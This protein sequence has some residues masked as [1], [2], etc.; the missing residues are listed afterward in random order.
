MLIPC[1]PSSLDL[2]AIADTVNIVTLAKRPAAFVLNAV[3][4][5]SS[6]AEDAEEALSAYPIPIAPVRIASRVVYVRSLAEG[7]GVPEFAPQGPAALEI[8][9]LFNF[10]SH[11]GGK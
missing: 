1:Q 11:Y 8:A 9:A 5:S 10:I 3:R 7:K 2:D 4:T 6:L